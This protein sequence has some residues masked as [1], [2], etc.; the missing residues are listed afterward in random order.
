MSQASDVPV[1]DAEAFSAL[2]QTLENSGPAAALDALV[3]HLTERGEF[4]ALLDAMLLKARFE[5]GLPLV[6]AGALGE[7]PEPTRSKYEEKYVEAIRT[8]GGKLLDSGDIPAAWPYFRAIAE[9]EPIARALDAYEPGEGD[10]SLNQVVEVAFN[11]GANPR[12]GF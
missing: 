3:H 5:L 7:L 4:R 10:E 1:Q 12:K 9:T 8:V 11:Q 2:D 6:Q